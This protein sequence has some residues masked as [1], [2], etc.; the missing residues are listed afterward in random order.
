M[1]SNNW[2]IESKINGTMTKI[3]MSTNS[4]LEME[5]LKN[6]F[7]QITQN[8]LP[9]SDLEL[10]QKEVSQYSVWVQTNNIS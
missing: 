6:S 1:T 8:N 3:I 10:F 9:I 5:R 2:K 7:S 4:I